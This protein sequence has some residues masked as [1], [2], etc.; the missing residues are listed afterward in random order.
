MIRAA[1]MDTVKVHYT[2]QL[3][4]GTVFDQS[5]EDRPLR[6]IL[7]KGEVIEGFEEAVS[8]M[9]QGESKTVTIPCTKAYGTSNPELIEEVDRAQLPE[10]L[11]LK[12]GRQLE[13]TQEDESIILLMVTALTDTTVTLDANHPLAGKDLTFEITLQEVT[14]KPVD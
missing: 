8:G 13:V 1:T 9:Y 2:G 6:F 11:E 10:D 5:T 12:V 7:G 4:D 14:K 3:E